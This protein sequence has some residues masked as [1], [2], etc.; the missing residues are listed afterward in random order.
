MIRKTTVSMTMRRREQEE[1]TT[2]EYKQKD[3]TQGEE[4]GNIRLEF[5][6]ER[7]PKPS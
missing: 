2:T 5:E 6:K 4:K 1:Q 3:N 7:V